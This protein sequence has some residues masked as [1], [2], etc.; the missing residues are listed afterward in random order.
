[1]CLQMR[2]GNPVPF[3]EIHLGL[4]NK[5]KAHE[6]EEDR[7]GTATGGISLRKLNGLF[8][9]LAGKDRK[10]SVP[11]HDELCDIVKSL[12]QHIIHGKAVAEFLCAYPQCGSPPKHRSLPSF[13]T[14]KLPRWTIALTL[15][16][17]QNTCPYSAKIYH[18]Y[19][20]SG[21]S[22]SF[23]ALKHRSRLH[24]VMWM[25]RWLLK[26]IFQL[27]SWALPWKPWKGWDKL[28]TIPGN[29]PQHQCYPAA[30]PEPR[31]EGGGGTYSR[32]P[33]HLVPM[34]NPA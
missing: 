6:H 19:S 29:A 7:A 25:G 3:S 4:R 31:A 10:M 16:K 5:A 30:I 14:Q 1:M 20:I 28:Q 12:R 8:I 23:L 18:Y 26:R 9:L 21:K 22:T 11:V 32:S 33:D 2:F 17:N 27:M 24:A 34:S 13:H 15:E